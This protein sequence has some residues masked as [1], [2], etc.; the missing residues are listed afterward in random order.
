MSFEI[1]QGDK[2]AHIAFSST[3]IRTDDTISDSIDLGYGCRVLRRML[4][5]FDAW[6]REQLG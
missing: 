5:S 6:W 2:F 1:E 4:F 3:A